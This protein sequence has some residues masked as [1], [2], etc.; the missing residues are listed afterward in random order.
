MGWIAILLVAFLLAFIRLAAKGVYTE[1]H[2]SYRCADCGHRE[3][4]K[5]R[6]F[7]KTCPRCGSSTSKTIAEKGRETIFGWQPFKD[8]AK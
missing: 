4:E 7:W 2:T 3:H 5:I 8:E 1:W 6:F